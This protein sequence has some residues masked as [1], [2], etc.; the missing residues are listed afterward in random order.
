MSDIFSTIFSGMG[1]GRDLVGLDLLQSQQIRE[2]DRRLIWPH[3]KR[4][5]PQSVPLKRN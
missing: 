2:A 4:T 3:L 1:S 5:G